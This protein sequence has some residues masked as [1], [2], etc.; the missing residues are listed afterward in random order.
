[1]IVVLKQPG[2]VDVK[3]PLSPTATAAE[4]FALLGM[5]AKK[6]GLII[7]ES[8]FS[9]IQEHIPLLLTPGAAEALVMSIYRQV[10]TTTA[11]IEDVLTACLAEYQNP[12]AADV[13]EFQ[14]QL[15]RKEAAAFHVTT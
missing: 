11:K 9:S 8:L 2:R 5:V 1:M 6:R 7:P 15:A 12:I 10:R 14:I 13:M 4:G 3:I